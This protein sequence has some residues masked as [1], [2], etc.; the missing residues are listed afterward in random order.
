MTEQTWKELE[1]LISSLGEDTD[2]QQEDETRRLDTESFAWR[3][4][5]ETVE[6]MKRIGVTDSRV[7]FD[8]L[9]VVGVL[10]LWLRD[11]RVRGAAGLFRRCKNMLPVLCRDPDAAVQELQAIAVDGLR[12]RTL[13]NKP[14]DNPTAPEGPR[15]RPGSWS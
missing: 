13:E 11:R 2:G 6:D 14:A 1:S 9:D 3:W 7:F 5:V 10:A 4:A 8:F 12:L 15:T